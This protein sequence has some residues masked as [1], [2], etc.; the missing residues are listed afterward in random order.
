[1]PVPAG[2]SAPGIPGAFTVPVVQIAGAKPVRGA[3]P[4][5][6]WAA[7][8]RV[9]LLPVFG[10]ISLITFD[11]AQGLLGMVGVR[12]ATW[13][14]LVFW[15]APFPVMLIPAVQRNIAAS[16]FGGRQATT[17]ERDR[18][19][20]PW[21]R[22]RDR[23]GLPQG[24]YRVFVVNE[25]GVSAHASAGRGI[26]V[27][28]DAI[29]QAG[30]L[31]LEALFAHELGHHLRWHLVPALVVWW[32]QLPVALAWSLVRWSWK[33]LRAMGK[34]VTFR[35]GLLLQVLAIMLMVLIAFVMAV[36]AVPALVGKLCESLAE[37]AAGT[38]EHEADRVACELGTA[39]AL[40]RMLELA[41]TAGAQRTLLEKLLQMPPLAQRRA[42]RVR[43]FLNRP[44][45]PEQGSRRQDN[46]W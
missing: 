11:F 31:E 36:L 12:P 40:L 24:R 8:A 45:E 32:M 17:A 44:A 4:H 22:V 21:R 46:P 43:A 23:A 38:A 29:A 20:E 37:L 34:F 35:A 33:L 10:V 19:V 42:N 1:M 2:E 25:A 39:E 3:R 18:L 9:A 13:V 27:T 14:L 5:P 6:A 41:V 16:R 7:V 30:P 26:T 15:W 28:V